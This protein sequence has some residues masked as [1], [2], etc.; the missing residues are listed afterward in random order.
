MEE[1]S[2]RAI[3]GAGHDTECST[4]A[5]PE[6]SGIIARRYG[7]RD[8]LRGGVAAA[9]GAIL[10]GRAFA[11]SQ[12][13]GHHDHWPKHGGGERQGHGHGH[14]R[15]L[16]GFEPV[17]HSF[18]DGVRVPP[19]YSYQILIPEG[20][21]VLPGAPD[22]I[23]GDF[24]SGTDR[25]Q[26]VGA[27]HDG[28]WFFPLLPGRAGN[29]RGL[30]CINHE[31]I[32]PPFLHPTGI[33]GADSGERDP[34]QVRKEIASHG[35][36]VYEIARHPD[37]RWRLIRGR[38]NRRITA[39]T[40]M[41]LTGP[42]AGSEFVRT[43]FD[44]EGYYTRGT[45]NNCAMGHTP[46]GTYLTAEENWAGYFKSDENPLPR[47]KARYG[48]TTGTF[49]YDWWRAPGD[50]FERFDTTP[51]G[52]S[53]RDDYRNEANCFGYIVEIDPFDPESV[54]K[55]RTA[56]GRF[57]HEGAWVAP[58]K[59]GRPV[60]VYSGDDARGEYLYKFVSRKPY[61]P[62]RARRDEL[63]EDGTLYVAVFSEDGTG[64]WVALDNRDPQ[65]RRAVAEWVAQDPANRRPFRN[66]ADVLVNTRTAADAVGATKMDR[67]EW[68][69]IDERTGYVYLTL[70]N[71][72][73][74]GSASQ[75][76][77]A[78]NPRAGNRDGHIVRWR[79]EDGCYEALRFRWEIFA[80]GGP[81]LET[82]RAEGLD[83]SYAAQVFPGSRRRTFLGEDAT[84]NSPDGCWTGPNGIL[85]IQTDGYSAPERGF[86]NQQMLA[87]D[88][89]TGEVRR[90]LVGPRD[91][92]ITGITSTPDGRTLFVNIQHPGERGN[93]T[94]PGLGGETR[95]RSATLVIW[96]NDGGV[97][98]T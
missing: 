22:Y 24:N 93:S 14:E 85:W 84:F 77:D 56:L 29:A 12:G 51:R 75:P 68:V 62:G 5:N 73:Q 52:A 55:K 67:P 70:T 98:G 27:H 8:V 41:E 4:S 66:Q 59:A 71:N 95:P 74:R 50:E 86:G 81:T 97:V 82:V 33:I 18:E 10:T 63:L 80:F 25:E 88:P 90:F 19:G 13:R 32:D 60:V 44:H 28:M 69:T 58:V 30:L 21:P 64:R 23:P 9:V 36:G 17:P 15:K 6:L 42:V 46:W 72:T 48:V 2:T 16:L 20:E 57:A 39:E 35:V 61:F 37:G 38:Y 83:E 47:E 53:A 49:G 92:E 26:Q 87:A 11:F 79:E 76:V 94:W 78:V 54:P 40:V 31:N 89:E 65:F 91:C 3:V 7:R 34:D 1:T 96:K 45:L 43:R